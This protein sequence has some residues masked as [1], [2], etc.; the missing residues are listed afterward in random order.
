MSNNKKA[1][2]KEMDKLRK[3]F[4]L[5]AFVM[6][7]FAAPVCEAADDYS[8]YVRVGLKYGG[9][10]VQTASFSSRAD[11]SV[12][13]KASMAVMANIPA[14]TAV[15][16]TS[17]G[18]AMQAEG[19]FIASSNTVILESSD[20]ISY[21]GA[22]YRG[23]FELICG[24]DKMTVINTVTMA[25]YLSS[26]LGKEMSASW[27]KEALKAQAV[28]ARNYVLAN[29]GKH[30]KYGFEVCAST[31]CQ[32]YGGVASEAASTR[33]AVNET[34]GVKV[35]YQGRTVSLL[36]FSCDGGYTEDSENV[37]T[38]EV[39]YMRGKK[40]IYENPEYATR[41][42]WEKVMT[43]AEAE[44]K[45][46][47]HGIN[48]GE[49]IDITIDEVSDNNGVIAMTFVGT[50]KSETVRKEKTRT[51]L[52]LNSQAFVIEKPESAMPAPAEPEAEDIDILKG[53][54][55]VLSADGVEKIESTPI[56]RLTSDGT[57]EVETED[58]SV[59]HTE[60]REPCESYTFVGHGWG[61]LVGMSQ[62][63]AYSMAM[64]GYSYEDILKFYYTDIEVVKE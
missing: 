19:Y 7:L 14:N 53:P 27:P 13:D 31:D 44:Q 58:E 61:H 41:Y 5:F 30:Q 4:L 59:V 48:V 11:I 63:G 46:R 51:V 10:A 15:T 36:Y 21:D 28:C 24:G 56:Y 49:L 8:T 23:T 55:F 52:G 3:L 33:A 25:D 47:N 35:K 22:K 38:N 54:Y 20:I 2:Q 18:G 6:L 32:V 29:S 12:I 26:L 57:E 50:E 40:D 34:N 64:K 9:S 43:R 42:N 37:W 16:V 17:Y 39:G 45:L 60:E 1:N 62:W